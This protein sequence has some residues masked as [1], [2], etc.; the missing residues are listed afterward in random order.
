MIGDHE[1]AGAIPVTQTNRRRPAARTPSIAWNTTSPES[2]RRSMLNVT[3]ETPVRVRPSVRMPPF[4][5]WD[6]TLRRSSVEVRVL[7][8]ARLGR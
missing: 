1:G 4:H 3:S 6:V 8:A 7:S 2:G 5:G